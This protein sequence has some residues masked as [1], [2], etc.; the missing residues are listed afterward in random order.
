MYTQIGRFSLHSYP[1]YLM[2]AVTLS[3]LV[4]AYR[5][6][7]V[8]N[9]R[10][11]ADVLV[12]ALVVGFVFARLEYVLLN[13]AVFAQRPLSMASASVGGLDWHGAAL[14]AL[15]GLLGVARW[16][17][18]PTTMLLTAFTPAV[19]MIAFAAWTACRPIGCAYGAEVATLAYHPIWAVTEGPDIF[20]IVAPRYDTATFGQALSWILTVLVGLAWW[21]G[22]ASLGSF[23]FISIA[24]CLGMLLI[25]RFRGDAAPLW[26]G[27]P[28][29][30][31]LD[32]LLLLGAVFVWWRRRA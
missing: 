6:R 28:A 5:L 2:L 30:L 7:S 1:L 12:A 17:R 25:G 9:P 26:L 14:G 4:A 13:W 11:Q 22:W 19:P 16:H 31:W 24:F 29:Y 23:W 3:A 18:L 20:G 21:R 27:Q 10:Q 32:A 8:A 15:L